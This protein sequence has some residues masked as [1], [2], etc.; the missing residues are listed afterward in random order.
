MR[1]GMVSNAASPAPVWTNESCHS[2]A[3][4]IQ[5]RRRQNPEWTT[6]LTGT[7]ILAKLKPVKAGPPSFTLN[8]PIASKR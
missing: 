7:T 1:A 5:R 6:S 3:R 8:K 2:G 4:T